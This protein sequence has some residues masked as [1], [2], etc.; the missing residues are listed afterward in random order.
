MVDKFEKLRQQLRSYMQKVGRG[1][2][3]KI[4]NE[5]GIARQ[6]L[7]KLLDGKTFNQSNYDLLD[8][9]LREN[10]YSGTDDE[11]V[12]QRIVFPDT[13]QLMELAI[14]FNTKGN[15]KAAKSCLDIAT[16]IQ[17]IEGEAE[18]YK[19]IVENLLESL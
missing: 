18:R 17:K 19:M 13:L 7:Y 1:A 2:P 10:H 4:H 8:K 11:L 14:K 16:E 15:A 9:Y 12:T 3:T 5:T 6:S